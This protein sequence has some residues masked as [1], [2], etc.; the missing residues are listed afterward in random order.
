MSLRG[1]SSFTSLFSLQI[2][3]GSAK[4]RVIILLMF[5][6]FVSVPEDSALLYALS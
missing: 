3:H 2:Q 6:V 1:L 4:Y 5:K